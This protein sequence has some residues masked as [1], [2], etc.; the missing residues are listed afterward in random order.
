MDVVNRVTHS[1]SA[2]RLQTGK[3]I[4]PAV[5]NHRTH[6]ATLRALVTLV[7]AES[8]GRDVGLRRRVNA[9]LRA[10]GTT[11]D[12]I[13]VVERVAKDHGLQGGMMRAFKAGVAAA[14]MG[15]T[16]NTERGA[17][18]SI[19]DKES[20]VQRGVDYSGDNIGIGKQ[21]RQMK[22]ENETLPGL[23]KAFQK[24]LTEKKS[25]PVRIIESIEKSLEQWQ[26]IN[27]TMSSHLGEELS[28]TLKDDLFES[29]QNVVNNVMIKGSFD[30][31][32]KAQLVGAL[33]RAQEHLNDKDWKEKLLL[34]PIVQGVGNRQGKLINAG[35]ALA[36]LWINTPL[37]HEVTTKI[38]NAW[39]RV[40]VIGSEVARRDAR[41]TKENVK[42]NHRERA[43]AAVFDAI[44]LQA[45][46][47]ENRP[48][49]WYASFYNIATTVMST[50]TPLEIGK[51]TCVSLIGA[52]FVSLKEYKKSI[53]AAAIVTTLSA[54]TYVA[55][56]AANIKATY[57]AVYEITKH[58]DWDTS[59]AIIAGM[60]M[61]LFYVLVYG[62]KQSQ[63]HAWWSDRTTE[64]L[65]NM[66][67]HRQEWWKHTFHQQTDDNG[68]VMP[69]AYIRGTRGRDE[70][71]MSY[72]T[73]EKVFQPGQ[74]ERCEHGATTE[75]MNAWIQ[76]IVAAARQEEAEGSSL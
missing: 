54:G 48:L 22:T 8:G 46:S 74:L 47:I 38:R 2:P 16:P 21:I 3:K 65:T 14:L 63:P 18:L 11:G 30:D 20:N 29:L 50:A 7:D 26:A 35:Y 53:A 6:M 73:R 17:A 13:R 41:P 1:H 75:T 56:D 37:H 5:T 76:P 39:E 36:G 62:S 31:T 55:T 49:A 71:Q 58:I 44:T 52:L 72:G 68:N 19:Y 23:H 33:E 43:I 69:F 10:G 51:W 42:V 12:C 40:L 70:A 32:G 60:I 9:T 66:I 57:T 45:Q 15:N 61:M 24:Y 25:A 67:L 28:T 59:D 64:Q 4:L 34:Q 27:A